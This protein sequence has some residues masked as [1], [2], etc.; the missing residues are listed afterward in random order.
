[1][2]L[3]AHARRAAAALHDSAEAVDPFGR[4]R[5][6]GSL[7]RRRARSQVA[8]AFVLLVGL[9]VAG[10]LVGRRDLPAVGPLPSRATIPVG[11]Q[12][13]TVVIGQGAV[14][15]ANKLD[16]SVS[17]I[18][19]QTN[20]VVATISV[21]DGVA[22][23]AVSRDA[24]WTGGDRRG[25]ARVVRIDPRTNRVVAAVPVGSQPS[26]LA[27]T[28][29]AVWVTTLIDGTITRID[30]Q[31]N[32]VTATIHTGAR[33]VQ[34][35]ADDR[36]VWVAY[37]QDNRVRR[38]DPQTNRVVATLRVAQPQDITLGFGSVWVP[39]GQ[40]GLVRIDPQ[41]N[42]ATSSIRVAGKPNTIAVGAGAVWVRHSDPDGVQRI[43]PQTN[44]ATATVPV[45]SGLYG[46]AV[47]EH[48]LWTVEFLGDTVTR[49]QLPK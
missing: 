48:W 23:L 17:R 6:L 22:D 13:T 33:P 42:T 43:D 2:N 35:A 4:L 32:Q 3:D 46:L 8:V 45:A 29:D 31:T 14:W 26:G 19:P 38:I 28:D 47:D 9:V 39:R 10:L 25:V 49:L 40:S 11:R 12:P 5:D 41:T 34:V 30:S 20:R 44:T 16:N 27:A 1:M 24:V 15:V 7:E 36:A 37:P 18:D 21:P